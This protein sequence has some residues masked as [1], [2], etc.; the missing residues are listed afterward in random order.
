MS[1]IWGEK[2]S[3]A[4]K[5]IATS[6]V[7]VAVQAFIPGSAAYMAATQ[8]TAIVSLYYLYT[9]NKDFHQKL[10][11]LYFLLLPLK[12]LKLL[13]FYGFNHFYHLRCS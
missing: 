6:L 8:A 7:T 3:N 13:C 1:D 5:I 10:L 9:G 12:Q 4:T 11:L 2:T